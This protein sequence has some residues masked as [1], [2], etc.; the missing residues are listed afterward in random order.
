MRRI[1]ALT[2]TPDTGHQLVS[3][4]SDSRRSLE[5]RV[6][7]LSQELAATR[8]EWHA[9]LAEKTRIAKRFERLL[10]ALPGAVVVLDGDGVVQ[11]CNSAARQLLGEPLQRVKWRTLVDRAFA[12]RR[13]DGHEISL[14]SGRRVNISTCSLD[15]EPGQI[16]LLKDITETRQ[17]QEQLGQLQ[18]LSEMGRMVAA[19]AHQIRTPLASALLYLSGLRSGR[20]EPPERLRILDK[21]LDRLRHLEGLV[22][23]MLAF[24]RQGK[25]EVEEISIGE[26]VADFMGSLEAQ[27]KANGVSL[28]L[29][30]G[31]RGLHIRGNT[32]ALRSAFQNLIDNA[33]QWGGHGGHLRVVVRQPSAQAVCI[34]FIDEGPGIAP[35]LQR[36]VVKPFF[37]TRSGGTGLGL[38]VVRGIISAHHGEL[39]IESNPPVP[40]TTVRIT[41]PRSGPEEAVRHGL[42]PAPLL[43]TLARSEGVGDRVGEFSG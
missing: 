11:E 32:E 12:P 24:A 29:Q 1:G 36:Q 30:N 16:L 6:V 19:L 21:A 31:V 43:S 27:L 3:V 39:T 9:Q 42:S 28:E 26:F 2:Q 23:D 34:E 41:L 7:E 35:E 25:F 40:G 22:K 13:D 4:P 18:R 38:T 15:G 33:I 5:I 20:I 17:L 37:T 8:R 10:Q 14:K